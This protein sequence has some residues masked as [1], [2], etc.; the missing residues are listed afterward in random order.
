M[1]GTEALEA[2]P[3]G[4]PTDVYASRDATDDDY[5]TDTR[6]SVP[7]DDDY[8]TDTLN[9]VLGIFGSFGV[10]DEAHDGAVDV[11]MSLYCSHCERRCQHRIV[12]VPSGLTRTPAAS[13]A[14]KFRCCTCNTVASCVGSQ[15]LEDDAA[16]EKDLPGKPLCTRCAV[17]SPDG[18]S[19]CAGCL[20]RQLST[21][22]P[23]P[24][25]PG[26][27]KRPSGSPETSAAAAQ[28]TPE[29]E[30]IWQ[31]VLAHILLPPGI[32]GDS[33]K[34][35]S[36]RRP[37]SPTQ[38]MDAGG[39]AVGNGDQIA[40]GLRRSQ[41][42]QGMHETAD[43]FAAATHNLPPL[44]SPACDGVAEP[45]LV[46]ERTPSHVLRKRSHSTEPASTPFDKEAPVSTQ[47]MQGHE[48]LQATA[49]A[50]R[51]VMHVSHPVT[52]VPDELAAGAAVTELEPWEYL[53]EA[54][55]SWPGPERVNIDRY[56]AMLCHKVRLLSV[57][58][59]KVWLLRC[60]SV[61]CHNVWLLCHKVWL[62]R[63]L[64]SC[65]GDAV[66]AMKRILTHLEWRQV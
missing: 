66:W 46:A 48:R 36:R 60:V 10:V 17:E 15:L 5:C 50:L 40:S 49:E 22:S 16:A 26:M 13:S 32:D 52:A 55:L 54:L 47:L 23:S 19:F 20:M 61:L 27:E 3:P 64:R 31:D 56:R 30:Q 6:N 21:V 12:C 4:T 35:L 28:Q 59:H 1:A 8:F 18:R 63:W 37:R 24:D 25:L 38:A 44:P 57:L 9:S 7:A 2:D 43:I 29:P 39:P 34:K 58:C 45:P 41:S 51:S 65:E 53:R 42:Q 14:S 62:L 33:G 11:A